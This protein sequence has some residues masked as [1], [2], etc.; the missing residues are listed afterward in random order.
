MIIMYCAK[1]KI[2]QIRLA[3]KVTYKVCIWVLIIVTVIFQYNRLTAPH[4][5][6]SNGKLFLRRDYL[7]AIENVARPKCAA[8]YPSQHS[9]LC[10]SVETQIISIYS[11][12][13]ITSRN[14]RKVI[15]WKGNQ[16]RL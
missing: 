4:N 1:L 3:Y 14:V 7:R 6:S 11:Q 9:E 12:N 2:L 13:L 8:T 15:S 5:P 16:M 10:G